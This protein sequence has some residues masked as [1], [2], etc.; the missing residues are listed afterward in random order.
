M[1]EDFGPGSTM[2][3]GGRQMPMSP[4]MREKFPE[5]LIT[6]V[7]YKGFVH[8]DNHVREPNLMTC[9]GIH[10]IFQSR[11]QMKAAKEDNPLACR[12]FKKS[13]IMTVTPEGF[14]LDMTSKEAG[15]SLLHGVH[16]KIVLANAID[17]FIYVVTR[18]A[19]KAGKY[20]C[21]CMKGE[22]KDDNM[23]NQMANFL[24]AQATEVKKQGIGLKTIAR[25]DSAIRNDLAAA[26]MRQKILS[27][28]ENPDGAK[29]ADYLGSP[30]N[31]PSNEEELMALSMSDLEK[32]NLESAPEPESPGKVTSS[33]DKILHAMMW[34]HG[35]IARDA[36]DKRLVGKPAGSFLVRFSNNKNEYAISLVNKQNAVQHFATVTKNGSLALNGHRNTYES[37][38]DLVDHYS[39]HDIT[40][41]GDRC[42]TPVGSG[43]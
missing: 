17:K 21:H 29:L 37:V 33:K 8:C 43:A 41:Q 14:R 4:T 25:K 28:S 42:L 22:D 19:N 12:G 15:G 40:A 13:V 6:K 11:K 39:R 10:Q 36:A 2:T 24:T 31:S 27:E 7:S 38:I 5:V 34:Y 18:R 20:T 23:V 16:P 35:T 3:I 32:L 26:F 9:E 1:A 30:V